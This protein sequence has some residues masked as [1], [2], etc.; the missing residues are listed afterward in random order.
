MPLALHP[1]LRVETTPPLIVPGISLYSLDEDDITSKRFGALP[2]LPFNPNALLRINAEEYEEGARARLE[3][4][5]VYRASPVIGEKEV[6]VSA[7]VMARWIF[8]SVLLC[9]PVNVTFGGHYRTRVSASTGE[10]STVSAG[11][12]GLER[13]RFFPA[14]QNPVS[15]NI[16]LVSATTLR[17]EEYFRVSPL[18]MDRIAV[19]LSTFW[20]SAFA[21]YPE[22]TFLGFCTVLESLLSTQAQEVTHQLAERASLVLRGMGAD[23]VD[24]YKMVKKLYGTRSDIVHGRG[25]KKAD[26]KT[27]KKRQRAKSSLS[28]SDV[29]LLLHPMSRMLPGGELRNLTGVTASIFRGIIHFDKLYDA[30]REG[31]DQILDAVF[32]R[33]LLG[34]RPTPQNTQ[35]GRD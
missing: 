26:L 6:F 28:L 27:I 32:L 33:A 16:A 20:T 29:D 19:A 7:R 34:G 12:L 23:P 15:I 24:I 13:A 31:D 8:T 9:Y 14:Q 35:E 3:P 4:K 25:A 18:R 5:G 2:N 17:V 21:Q 11:S 22:Q 30:L 10:E 1:A